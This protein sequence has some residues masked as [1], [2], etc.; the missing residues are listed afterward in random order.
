MAPK[1][2]L[3]NNNGNCKTLSWTRVKDDALVDA[4]M[5]EYEKGNKVSD[6]FGATTYENIAVELTAL[7]GNKVDK[8]EIKN[9]WK[10]LKRNFTEYYDIFKGG[11][12]GFSWNSTTQIWD[13]ESEVWDAFIE[14]KPKASNWKNVPFPNYEKMLILYEHESEILKEARKQISSITNED[15]GENIQEID[16]RVARNEMTLESFHVTYDFSAP[17]TQL[18]DLSPITN[19]GK[20]TKLRVVK[21]RHTTKSLNSKNQ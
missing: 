21:N 18:S 2:N 10:T 14:S 19:G 15:F 6:I 13:A 8:M 16:A 17:E 5:H 1:S 9:R 7:F 4:F 11:M 20:R 12:S 3:P